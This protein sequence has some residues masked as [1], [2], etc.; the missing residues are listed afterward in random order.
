[1]TNPAP[2]LSIDWLQ[3]YL[4]APVKKDLKWH[5]FFVVKRM[6]YQTRQFKIVEELFHNNRRIATVTREPLS[7][8]IQA[9]AIIVK[10]DNWILYSV[11]LFA[12]VSEF[13]ALNSLVFKS[14]SRIDLCADFQ[15][16]DNNMIPSSFIKNYL[17]GLYLRL[18]RT[19]FGNTYFKQ[20]DRDLFFNSLKFGSNLSDI[21]IYLYNKTLEMNNGKWKPWIV[22]KWLLAGFPPDI[23]TW[24]LEVSIK[25][26]NKLIIN[27]D[28]AEFSIINTLEVLKPSFAQLTYGSLREKYFSF[29]V[30]DSQAKK[31]RMKPVKLFSN[32]FA[33]YKVVEGDKMLDASRSDKIFIKKLEDVNCELRGLSFHLNSN[34]DMLKNE[35][36]ELTGL[37][38]W[39][40]NRGLLS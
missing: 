31:N 11:D 20:M 17:N 2:T 36:I 1:M 29:V 24:R 13:I 33:N 23:D 37:R 14:I 35:M 38:E 26:A 5:D 16:F 6:P 27:K 3:L 25:D 8:I 28:T 7:N 32:S 30:K 18:G 15:R 22:A 39:A 4:E 21:S 12:Y 40:A 34:I 9:N 19:S 10:F